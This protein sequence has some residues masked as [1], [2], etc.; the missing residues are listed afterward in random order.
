[1]CQS[2]QSLGIQMNYKVKQDLTKSITGKVDYP[3]Q[4]R[5]LLCQI[6]ILSNNRLTNY[7][8]IQRT[9]ID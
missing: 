4:I 2:A 1:M 5:S 3:D 6:I 7:A 9:I 8:L